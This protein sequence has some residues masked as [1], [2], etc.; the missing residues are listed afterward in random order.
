MASVDLS[1]M[2]LGKRRGVV[3]DPRTLRMAS[4]APRA[5]ALR[6]PRGVA[7]TNRVAAWPM[8]ANDRMNDC[9]CAAMGHGLL[10]RSA[11]EGHP[12]R[13]TDAE[14]LELYSRVNGGRDEGAYMLDV[15][16]EARRLGLGG[17]TIGA[18]VRVDLSDWAEVKLA[19]WLFGGVYL[20]L[21]LPVAAQRQARWR[22]PTVTEQ[23]AGAP[24]FEPGSWGG[25][26][27]EVLWMS[28]A[29]A[30]CVTWARRQPMTRG[31]VQRYGDEAWAVLSP[32]WLDPRTGRSPQGFDVEQ[33]R[34]DLAAL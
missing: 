3:G 9:T 15:L 10:A 8:H 28:D 12:V 2:R 31:F 24:G 29:S 13:A 6:A 30:A 22:T 17:R 16:N 19:C 1:Q 14:V 11:R 7:V 33:L 4:Y 27:V 5:L 34:A 18:F 23:R 26:A 25:H 21:A 32:E 20:G